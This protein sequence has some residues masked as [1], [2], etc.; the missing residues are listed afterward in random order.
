MKVG[1]GSANPKAENFEFGPLNRMEGWRI[2]DGGAST[3]ESRVVRSAQCFMN[4]P[5]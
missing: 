2:S 4:V 5:G 1:H 3:T